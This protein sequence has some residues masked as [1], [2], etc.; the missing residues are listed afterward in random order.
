MESANGS[1]Q[2]HR[3]PTHRTVSP[4]PQSY[5]H[6]QPA[7]DVVGGHSIVGVGQRGS[8][9]G[10]RMA[11]LPVVIVPQIRRRRL[12]GMTRSVMALVHRP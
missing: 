7:R 11:C 12:E 6:P 2:I 1:L 10:R 8:M 5:D 3:A 4:A 9:L